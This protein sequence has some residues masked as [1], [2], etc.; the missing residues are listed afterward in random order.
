M[1]YPVLIA[2]TT[3]PETPETV[4][5]SEKTSDERLE[6]LNTSHFLRHSHFLK[7]SHPGLGLPPACRQDS[8]SAR[9]CTQCITCKPRKKHERTGD[10][11]SLSFSQTVSPRTAPT[12]RASPGLPACKVMYPVHHMQTKRKTRANRRF[13]FPLIFSNRLTPDSSY[14]LRVARTPRLQGP[15]HSGSPANR[16]NTRA[17]RRFS[18]PLIFSNRLTPDSYYPLRAAKTPRLQ[19]PVH[20]GPHAN[21]GKNTNEPAILKPSHA[22]EA[23]IASNAGGTAFIDD[24]WSL[25]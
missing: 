13:S 5:P 2:E 11:H 12:T 14:P 21:H 3:S 7:P 10:S 25:P 20:S 4:K 9:S 6:I 15:I 18:F 23:V 22:G 24:Y 17:S 16:G 8:L 19:G 1:A